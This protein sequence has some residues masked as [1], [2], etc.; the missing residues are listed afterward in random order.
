LKIGSAFAINEKGRP[1]VLVFL[2]KKFSFW[3]LLIPVWVPHRN[4]TGNLVLDLVLK[5][6]WF[7]FQNKN[8]TQFLLK[9]YLPKPEWIASL[10]A[11]N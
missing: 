7:Q 5:T 11:P 10:K 3:K 9:F 4:R 2:F 1:L 8:Q 6:I